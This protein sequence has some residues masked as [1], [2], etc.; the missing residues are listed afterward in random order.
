M[1]CR[2][3]QGLVI[4]PLLFVVFINVT[5]DSVNSKV[6]VFDCDAVMYNRQ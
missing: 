4:C 3:S 6:C 5:D 1:L 2:V